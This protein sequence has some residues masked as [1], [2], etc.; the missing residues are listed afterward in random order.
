MICVIGE[1]QDFNLC[2]NSIIK[3]EYL[4]FIK[5]DNYIKTNI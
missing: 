1:F 4:K 2:M 3:S 5:K